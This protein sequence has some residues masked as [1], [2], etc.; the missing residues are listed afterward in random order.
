MFGIFG[1]TYTRERQ[2]GSL[3]TSMLLMEHARKVAKRAGEE[4]L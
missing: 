1:K 2:Q 3:A 4:K